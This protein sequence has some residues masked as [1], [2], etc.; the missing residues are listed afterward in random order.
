MF[1][2]TSRLAYALP[3]PSMVKMYCSDISGLFAGN[4]GEFELRYCRGESASRGLFPRWRHVAMHGSIVS[5]SG[6]LT[7]RWRLLLTAGLLLLG[8]VGMYAWWM[9]YRDPR[10]P[11]VG[12]K[13]TEICRMLDILDAPIDME[14]F[15]DEMSLKDAIS[16][17]YFQL[18]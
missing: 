14:D 7:I 16:K 10:F 9:T 1:L 3:S 8:A 12:P 5:M 13:S 15:R 6:F 2:R 11:W 4:V 18:Q 17:L